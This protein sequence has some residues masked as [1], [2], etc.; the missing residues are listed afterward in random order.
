MKYIIGILIEIALNLQIA[1][2][3]MDTLMM[4]ILPVHEHGTCFYLFVSFSVSSSL[5]DN[6]PSTSLLQP[7]L[8]LSLGILFFLKQL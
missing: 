4:L 6:F 3:S 7:W 5:S 1:L 2:V 8:G